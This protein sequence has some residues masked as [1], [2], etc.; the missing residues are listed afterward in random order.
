MRLQ[1]VCSEDVCPRS[2]CALL[3]LNL[4]FLICKVGTVSLSLSEF[5]E[6]YV[7]QMASGGDIIGERGLFKVRMVHPCLLITSL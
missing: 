6:N 5:R 7:T 4:S 1:K 2:G 3:P